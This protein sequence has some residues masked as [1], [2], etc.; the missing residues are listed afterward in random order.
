MHIQILWHG[1]KNWN[2]IFKNDESRSKLSNL[3]EADEKPNEVSSVQVKK[4]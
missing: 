1:S 4:L 2:V 3:T